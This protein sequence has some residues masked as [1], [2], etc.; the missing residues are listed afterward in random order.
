MDGRGE[1]GGLGGLEQYAS[2]VLLMG[3]GMIDK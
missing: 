3:E 1:G 2:V